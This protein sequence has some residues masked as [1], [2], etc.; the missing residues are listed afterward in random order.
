[1]GWKKKDHQF[2]IKDHPYHCTILIISSKMDIF[3][4]EEKN[5]CHPVEFGFIPKSATLRIFPTRRRGKCQ[6]QSEHG[7]EGS[8]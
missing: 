8:D 4:V 6:K 1:M 2:K 5:D 7:F 3:Y